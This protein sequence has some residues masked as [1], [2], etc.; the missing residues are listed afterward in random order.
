MNSMSSMSS[1]LPAAGTAAADT[2]GN[3]GVAVKHRP[4]GIFSRFELTGKVAVVTGGARGL[5]FEMARALCEAGLAGIAIL[6]ILQE[7]GESAIKEL[8]ADFGLTASFYRVD[9]RDHEAVEEVINGVVRDFG[10]VDVLICSAGVADNIAAEDYPADRFKRVMDINL[11]GVFFCAQS[12]AKHMISSGRGGSMIFIGS[13][14]GSIVNYPQPQCAY[15]ASKAAVIHLM[16]SLA[17]EWAPHKI[18]CNTISPGYMNTLLNEKFDPLLKKV[19]FERTPV[20]RMGHVSDLNGAAL[21]LASDASA[22]T[23]GSDLLVDGGYCTW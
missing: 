22:F 4:G 1:T 3:G 7:F 12:C 11:N 17:A 14:S 15:N 19:W 10:S 9:V 8:H 6:D 2:A 20:G 23:T 21:Y 16:K 18:R 5:G 13:M